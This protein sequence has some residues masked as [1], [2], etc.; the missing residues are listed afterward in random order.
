MSQIPRGKIS[1]YKKIAETLDTKAYR[2]VGS[3]MAK[4]PNP[5]TVPC[6]RI[7]NNNGKIGGY[8]LGVNEKIK[9]LEDEGF[10]IK[11]GKV[12]NFERH[13]HKFKQKGYIN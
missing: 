13:I 7:I 6:H 4:N 1:T 2:A 5:I 8:A 10:T 11:K 9:L 3:A 12:L